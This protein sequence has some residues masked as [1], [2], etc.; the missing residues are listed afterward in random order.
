MAHPFLQEKKDLTRM[1]KM[2]IGVGVIGALILFYIFASPY[3]TVYQMKNAA[4]NQDGE[5]LS[6]YIDFLTLRRSLKDQIN[7]MI[8]KEM[9]KEAMND[10]LFAYLGAA[11]GTIIVEKIVDTYVTP[12]GLMQL[13]EGGKLE[14]KESRQGSIIRRDSPKPFANASLSYE[15]FNKF[16]ITMIDQQ[17]DNEVKFILRRRGL[18]WKLTE[19]ILPRPLIPEFTK[20][21]EKKAVKDLGVRRLS[22]KDITG[23]FINTKN[24]GQL[25]VVKGTVVNNY[26][27]PCSFILLKSNI[28]DGE[29]QVVKSKRAYAGNSFREDELNKLASREIEKAMKNPRGR[30]GRNVNVAPGASVSFMI[31]FQ[32]LPNDMSEFTVEA[33]SSSL[34]Q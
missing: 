34:R 17:G 26:R 21:P 7:V 12:A 28:L 10:N 32:N 4:E 30:D 3:L 6:E 19:I 33:V 5:A 8:G 1:K 25:F 13:M 20:T 14:S 31:V 18:S 23:S 2:I 11:F 16:S 27:K 22:F 29:A 15:S 24:K 9:A